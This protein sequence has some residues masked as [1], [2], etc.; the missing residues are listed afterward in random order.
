M[1]RTKTG[2]LSDLVN[3]NHR[4]DWSNLNV[5][6]KA[7]QPGE[8]LTVTCPAQVTIPSFR[9]IILTTGRRLHSG[10][11]RLSTKTEKRKIHCFLSPR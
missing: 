11:W 9:S 5:K 4:A 1:L 8:L 10:E 7:L 3:S 6:L 2:R